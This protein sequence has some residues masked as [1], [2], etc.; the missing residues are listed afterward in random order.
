MAEFS[1][2]KAKQV[3]EDGA[4]QAK[5]L[6]QD[7][8]KIQDL[9]KQ[10]QDYL[11]GLPIAGT[12]FAKVPVMVSMVKSYITK[13]YTEVSPKVVVSLVSAFLYLVKKHDIIP[14]SI[15]LIGRVDDIA[16]IGL[17]INLCG[18]ELDAYSAWKEAQKTAADTA[19]DPE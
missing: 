13:E 1:A 17:A 9:L 7:P 16:V 19:E 14:D 3:L 18:K 5:E 15:P 4:E 6:I 8:S 10:I 2:E 12:T 11:E